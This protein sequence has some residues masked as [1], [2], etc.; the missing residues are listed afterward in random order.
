MP[1]P[2]FQKDDFGTRTGGWKV[3]RLDKGMRNDAGHGKGH[4]GMDVG[5]TGKLVPGERSEAH[6]GGSFRFPWNVAKSKTKNR[7]GREKITKRKRKKGEEEADS[8]SGVHITQ[9][10]LLDP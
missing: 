6:K 7:E 2:E 9:Q 5:Y 8:L 4:D 3:T 1:W 10:R